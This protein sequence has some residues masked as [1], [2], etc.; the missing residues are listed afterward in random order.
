MADILANLGVDSD[1]VLHSGSLDILNDSSH[2][3]E[4]TDLVH[5]DVEFPDEGVYCNGYVEAAVGWQVDFSHGHP[6]PH[7]V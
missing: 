1:Q 2:I 5:N 3:H 7:H 4:C 6:R